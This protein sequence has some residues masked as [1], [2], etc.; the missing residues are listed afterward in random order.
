MTLILNP[1]IVVDINI[2]H[3]NLID[4]NTGGSMKIKDLDKFK[5]AQFLARGAARN[6]KAYP[7]A[8]QMLWSRA[9]I[10]LRKAYGL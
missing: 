8:S 6:S 1:H 9:M 3:V 5:K 4:I 2:I 10:N 7:L